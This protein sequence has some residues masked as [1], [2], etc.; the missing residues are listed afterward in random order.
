MKKIYER[1]LRIFLIRNNNLVTFFK[2]FIILAMMFGMNLNK[3]FISYM[4]YALIFD[5]FMLNQKERRFYKYL[6]N[7]MMLIILVGERLLHCSNNF[8]VVNII[9]SIAY[10]FI[11]LLAIKVDL[12][13]NRVKYRNYGFRRIIKKNEVLMV[14]K[15]ITIISMLLLVRVNLIIILFVATLNLLQLFIGTSEV[16][17]IK[18][19]II[20]L[21]IFLISALTILFKTDVNAMVENLD[22]LAILGILATIVFYWIRENMK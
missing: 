8:A 22:M 2:L 18:K 14:T 7:I 20:D 21:L 3:K 12:I 16:D 17:K 15:I 9:I 5:V 19:T 6:L 13:A 1:K 4:F 10:I 11:I